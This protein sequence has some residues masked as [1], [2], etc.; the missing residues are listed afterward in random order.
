MTSNK[1]L[2]VALIIAAFFLGSLTNKVA[3]LEK[4]GSSDSVNNVKGSAITPA[5]TPQQPKQAKV[6]PVTSSD[7]IRGNAKAKITLIV[8]SDF[9]C[10]YCQK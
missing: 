9:E 2:V 1:T 5:D 10:P 8:Y 7:H 4:N 6:K 3:T